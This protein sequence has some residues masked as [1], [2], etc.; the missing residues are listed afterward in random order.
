MARQSPRKPPQAPT[1]ARVQWTP[2]VCAALADA[3]HA[4]V[5]EFTGTDGYGACMLYAVA[6]WSPLVALDSEAWH[7]Q[8]GTARILAEPPDGWLEMNG[9]LPG[10]IERG[11]FHCW[12]AQ[13]SPRPQARPAALVD[14]SSRHFQRMCQEM[15]LADE[16]A[17]IPWTQP[18]PP[19]IWTSGD[20]SPLVHWAPVPALCRA[21]WEHVREH[22]DEYRPLRNLVST[23]WHQRLRQAR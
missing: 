15:P 17:R 13:A 22:F 11:E 14:L 4:A 7:L 21:I 12:L 8:A 6:G 10:A 23:H 1:P 9:Q 16:S 3:V 2:T 5:C 18:P 19:Y 20:Q